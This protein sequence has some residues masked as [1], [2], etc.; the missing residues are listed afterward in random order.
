MDASLRYIFVHKEILY[1]DA[2]WRRQPEPGRRAADDDDD[3]RGT[4][5]QMS[6]LQRPSGLRPPRPPRS[7]FRSGHAT[8]L[9]TPAATAYRL[10]VAASRDAASRKRTMTATG[11]ESKYAAPRTP[12]R[13]PPGRAPAPNTPPE[14]FRAVG[15]GGARAPSTLPEALVPAAGAGCEKG[16][17]KQGTRVGGGGCEKG[18]GK[19]VSAAVDASSSGGHWDG[20]TWQ[21][22]QR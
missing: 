15:V 21:K 17:G 4:G 7:C 6:R 16:T 20:Y 19:A 2:P 18:A 1:W 8:P 9:A 14:A 10:R 11:K 22:R 5:I 12:T 13:P 3:N